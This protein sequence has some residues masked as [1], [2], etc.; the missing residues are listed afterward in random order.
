MKKQHCLVIT[1]TFFPNLTESIITENSRYEVLEFLMSEENN[2]NNYILEYNPAEI[3]NWANYHLGEDFDFWTIDYNLRKA[4]ISSEEF[5]K[6]FQ[7][8]W[9]LAREVY[10]YNLY[11]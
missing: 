7:T 1:D 5:S 3:I 6:A 4:D 11:T 2:G 10:N 9:M 8:A